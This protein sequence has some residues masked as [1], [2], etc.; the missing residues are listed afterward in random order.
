[1]EALRRLITCL[2][3]S[4]VL[5]AVTNAQDNGCYKRTVKLPESF[6][7]QLIELAFKADDTTE[8]EQQRVRRAIES[9]GPAHFFCAEPVNL[10]RKGNPGLLIHM[11]DVEDGFGGM[12]SRPVWVYERTAK[13]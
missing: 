3:A 2:I 11:A 9:N 7:R 12:Y 1:M 8:E 10:S 13:G 6:A 4:A 5:A